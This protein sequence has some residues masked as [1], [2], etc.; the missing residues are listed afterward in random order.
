VEIQVI[1]CFMCDSGGVVVVLVIMTRSHL[2]VAWRKV[3]RRP[4]DL[5][6][7]FCTQVS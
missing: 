6:N 3:W 5:G 1:L 2:E 4:R 7:V